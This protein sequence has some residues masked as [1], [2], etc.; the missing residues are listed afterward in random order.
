[1][2]QIQDLQDG[3]AERA[4][5]AL[6]EFLGSMEAPRLRAASA[7][8]LYCIDLRWH[9][10]PSQAQEA[11]RQCCL[12]ILRNGPFTLIVELLKPENG[13]KF[14]VTSPDR[15]E[16]KAVLKGCEARVAHQEVEYPF[17]QAQRVPQVLDRLQ[18]LVEKLE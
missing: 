7:G 2:L 9:Q 6:V 17:Q 3:H 13:L 11:L 10:V 18:E 8:V 5:Q 12:D 15:S 16:V 1:M 14:L 4:L